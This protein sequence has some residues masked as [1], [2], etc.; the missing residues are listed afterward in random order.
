MPLSPVTIITYPR[1]SDVQIEEIRDEYTRIRIRYEDGN[2]EGKWEGDSIGQ[3]V[4]DVEGL[5][6]QC[7][8]LTQKVK[9][10]NIKVKRLVEELKVKDKEMEGLKEELKKLQESMDK[11]D[12]N[13]TL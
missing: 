7:Q 4:E 10:K 9:D 8:F 2:W 5:L 13:N 1:L 11:V 6:D 3:L 12:R